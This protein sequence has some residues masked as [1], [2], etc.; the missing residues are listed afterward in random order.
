VWPGLPQAV[1]D[2]ITALVNAT[3]KKPTRRPRPKR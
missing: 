3:A 2:A 1:R